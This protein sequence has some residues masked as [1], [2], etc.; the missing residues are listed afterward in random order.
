M[1]NRSQTS[2]GLS[3]YVY[4]GLH[5]VVTLPATSFASKTDSVMFLKEI[6]SNLLKM[7]Y[8][9]NAWKGGCRIRKDFLELQYEAIMAVNDFP[10]TNCIAEQNAM[11][12]V[13]QHL[14]PS[15]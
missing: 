8:S 1:A 6:V 4:G 10:C 14:L 11:Q 13:L 2:T 7:R 15:K 9:W 12:N 3:V 5:K